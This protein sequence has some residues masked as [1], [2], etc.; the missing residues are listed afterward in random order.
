[1][2]GRTILA[3]FIVI[4]ALLPGT[5]PTAALLVAFLLLAV[6]LTRP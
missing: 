3:A 1:M 6:L 4:A 2:R 5:C